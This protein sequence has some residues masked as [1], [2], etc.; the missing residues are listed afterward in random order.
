MSMVKLHFATQN[1][2]IGVQFNKNGK[3]CMTRKCKKTFS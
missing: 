1:S 2:A 3:S